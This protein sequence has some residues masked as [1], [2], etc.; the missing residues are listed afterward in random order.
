[1]QAGSLVQITALYMETALSRQAEANKSCRKHWCGAQNT[2]NKPGQIVAT[3]LGANYWGLILP[4]Q[5]QTGWH[6][7]EA[8]S[9]S[10]FPPASQLHL[11]KGLCL[12]A[13]Q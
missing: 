6:P 13:E 4:V 12:E 8:T 1:M 7:L 9:I 3:E 10:P 2:H 11:C 5:V